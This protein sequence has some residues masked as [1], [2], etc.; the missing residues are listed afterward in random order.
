MERSKQTSHFRLLDLPLEIRREIYYCCLPR[1]R[2]VILPSTADGKPQFSYPQQPSDQQIS[3]HRNNIL[4][5]SKQVS[6]ECLDILYGENRFRL[7]FS[8]TVHYAP[9]TIQETTE[10]HLITQHISPENRN[11][12]R[13]LVILALPTA[14]RQDMAICTGLKS[15]PEKL[16]CFHIFTRKRQATGDDT[17]Q[18]ILERFHQFVEFMCSRI[19][20]Q[21]T[22]R[23]SDFVSKNGKPRGG[24]RLSIVSASNS[25]SVSYYAV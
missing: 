15:V 8:A 18:V 21:A 25:P 5:L 4:L 13:F 16:N 6:E 14:W 3:G 9:R 20:P 7:S 1:G 12:I 11:R 17:E 10:P 19:T 24:M 2:L 22:V 23:L